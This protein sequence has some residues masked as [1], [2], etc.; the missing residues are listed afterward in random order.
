MQINYNHFTHQ[1]WLM[2]FTWSLSCCKS[3]QV[4]RTLL[5]ILADL[6]NVVVWMFSTCLLFL[7]LPVPLAIPWVLFRVHQ[8]QL[9]SLSRPFSVVVF[10][11][12]ARSR[13]LSL[14]SL[15]FV[16]TLRSAGRQS[17][18]FGRLSCFFCL[19]QR[20]V[21]WPRL[22]DPFVSQNPREL[23]SSYSPRWILGC[24]YTTCSY[25]Q[26]NFF[27]ATLS[28]L[29]SHPVVSNLILLLCSFTT[30]ANYMCCVM[31]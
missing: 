28:G 3:P 6:K 20:L 22:G 19:S 16:F 9:L 17:P 21:V 5:N 18:L 29:F 8:P 24:A 1:R 26:I 30:F 15:Y 14:V 27:S 2:V 11:S 25:E 31:K 4:S 10:S 12:L 23:C 7:S 13:D